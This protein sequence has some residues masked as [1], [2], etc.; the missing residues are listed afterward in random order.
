MTLMN[1]SLVALLLALSCPLPF[2]ETMPEDDAVVEQSAGSKAAARIAP[3]RKPRRKSDV[4]VP[5]LRR[6]LTELSAV[7]AQDPAA[8]TPRRL[9]RP[10]PL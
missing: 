4:Q 1:L 8:W 7:P 2:V 10:P 6:P 5:L 9:S 3:L